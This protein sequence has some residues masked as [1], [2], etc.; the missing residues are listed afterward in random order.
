MG[1]DRLGEAKYDSKNGSGNASSLKQPTLLN[2]PSNLFQ[3][4]LEERFSFKQLLDERFNAEVSSALFEAEG[5]ESLRLLLEI[6]ASHA[7]QDTSA[8][9]LLQY[10]SLLLRTGNYLTAESQV[11]SELRS[12]ALTDDLTGFYNRYGFLI[13]GMQFLKLARRNGQSVLLLLVD[14]DHFKM[15][16]AEFGHAEGDILLVR[17]ADVLRKIFRD[18]DLVASL[19]GDEFAVLAVASNGQSREAILCRLETAIK[20]ANEGDHLCELSMSAGVARSD[21][22][23]PVS[24]AALLALA[25][26]DMY[27]QKYV[28]LSRRVDPIPVAGGD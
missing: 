12:L 26:K 7:S 10:R 23:H 3:Q 1:A 18:A 19:G 21:Q 25:D 11:C 14:V 16:N 15:V 4:V 9:V 2:C 13:L 5:R 28:H 17:C 22:S 20:Q 27:E 8:E 24:L 6:A